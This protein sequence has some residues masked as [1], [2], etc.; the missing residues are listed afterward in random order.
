MPKVRILMLGPYG[1]TESLCLDRLKALRDSLHRIGYANVKLVA[2]FE[3]VPPYHP[4]TAAHFE[5]KSKE[6][7][8]TWA[9]GL[10]FVF[11]E[12][13]DNVGVSDELTFVDT[14]IPDLFHSSVIL[15]EEHVTLSMMIKGPLKRQGIESW[16]FLGDDA[17]AGL[18]QGAC[19]KI[20]WRK[21]WTV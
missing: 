10:L 16:N 21:F 9:S 15:V 17:L 12:G 7:I 1:P 13:C 19:S 6:K 2:D 4:N 20:L 14:K 3:D 8:L 11:L 18:A 5:V